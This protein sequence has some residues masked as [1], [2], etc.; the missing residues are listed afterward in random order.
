MQSP[1]TY[2]ELEERSTA[3]IWNKS[4]NRGFLE[5][6]DHSKKDQ[7]ADLCHIDRQKAIL[8]QNICLVTSNCQT[9]I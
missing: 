4:G 7:L 1:K 3:W 2:E 5:S 9:S 8:K 6:I